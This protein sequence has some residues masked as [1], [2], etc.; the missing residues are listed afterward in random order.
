MNL[1]LLWANF[2]GILA[3]KPIPFLVYSWCISVYISVCIGSFHVSL[4]SEYM[5]FASALYFSF[6]DLY[7]DVYLLYI[8]VYLPFSTCVFGFQEPNFNFPR[9]VS[10]FQPCTALFGSP[11]WLKITQR[12]AKEMD[13]SP[14]WTPRQVHMRHKQKIKLILIV[15]SQNKTSYRSHNKHNQTYSTKEKENKVL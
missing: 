5:Y 6:L 15:V 10:V 7:I 12:Y 14:N 1:S 8:I 3:F 2:A 9:L 11:G 13:L 4:A